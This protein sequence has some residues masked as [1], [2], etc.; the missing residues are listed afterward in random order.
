[1]IF[2]LVAPVGQAQ[3]PPMTSVPDQMVVPPVDEYAR[4]EV[5][6]IIEEGQRSFDN[7]A[8]SQPYQLVRLRVLSGPEV[9]KELEIRHGYDFPIR[10]QQKVAV[11]QTVVLVKTQAFGETTYLISDPY[12]LPWVGLIVAIFLVVAVFFGRFKGIGSVIGLLVSILILVK[13][14]VPTIVSGGNPVTTSLVGSVAIAV[15]SLYPAHGFSRRTSIALVSMLISLGLA[16]GLASLFVGLARLFGMGTE[17]AFYVQMGLLE[18]IDLKG[19]LLGGIIIGALGVLDDV[20]TG[21]AAA[22]DEIHKANPTLPFI[23][24]YRRGLSVGREHI[25]SLVN[26]LALAYIGAGLPLLLLFTTNTVQPLWVAMNAESIVEEIIRT[27]VG[28]T[29]LIFAVPITTALMAHILKRWPSHT[30]V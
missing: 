23:E 3:E 29:T 11:G 28:S 4:A 13:Y 8:Y 16:T 24:L 6:T 26:T 17:E 19:L 14:I 21:Q 10:E 18:N 7:E 15:L 9:G 22:V 12:R 25:T 1:M 5:M 27:L 2:F 30:S 20:T